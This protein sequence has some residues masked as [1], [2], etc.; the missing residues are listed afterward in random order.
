MIICKD[1]E[2]G[3]ITKF[4]NVKAVLRNINR[5]RSQDWIKYTKHDWKEGLREFTE[6]DLVEVKKGV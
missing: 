2:T 1:K 3:E 6:F 4:K 5:D